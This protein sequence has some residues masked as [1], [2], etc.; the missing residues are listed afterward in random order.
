MNDGDGNAVAH[1]DE[2]QLDR[3]RRRVA[4]PDELLASDAHIAICDRCYAAVKVDCDA[5]DL[6]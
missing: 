5:I 4:P 6:P 2:D 1:L 3:Y